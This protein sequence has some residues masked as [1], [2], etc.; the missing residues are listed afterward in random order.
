MKAI[1]I[2]LLGSFALYKM[3]FASKLLQAATIENIP[4]P[5]APTIQFNT[6]TPKEEHISEREKLEKQARII[7]ARMGE[8]PETVKY[9]G[10]SLLRALITDYT[11]SNR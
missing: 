1:I 8:K 10:E 3:G 5:T 6:A 2:I 4:R 11:N 9:M 7:V